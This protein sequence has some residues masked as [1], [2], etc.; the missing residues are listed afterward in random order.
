MGNA[1]LEW[2]SW[3]S[4][5]TAVWFTSQSSHDLDSG[6]HDL[7]SFQVNL[8]WKML[9]KH[10]VDTPDVLQTL[11]DQMVHMMWLECVKCLE[12]TLVYKRGPQHQLF[13]FYR[14]AAVRTHCLLGKHGQRLQTLWLYHKT[15]DL[16]NRVT[17]WN[18]L[19]TRQFSPRTEKRIPGLSSQTTNA[20]IWDNMARTPDSCGGKC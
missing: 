7:D 1:L 9:Q 17:L 5:L 20:I 11:M 8:S 14:P 18:D 15:Q 19:I 10:C 16:Y 12:M 6:A 2:V 4:S 3:L 13:Q